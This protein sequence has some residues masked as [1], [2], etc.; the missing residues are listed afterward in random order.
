M[1]HRH[2]DEQHVALVVRRIAQAVDAVLDHRVLAELHALG[3]AGGAGAVHHDADVVGARRR[4]AGRSVSR[5]PARPRTHRRSPP[6]TM[7][8]ST[9]SRPIAHEAELLEQLVPDEHDLGGAVVEDV[10]ELVAGQ[11][12]VDDGRRG[13]ELAAAEDDL[14]HRRVVL[15]EDRDPVAASDAVGLERAGCRAYGLPGLGPRP[16]AFAE[17]PARLVGPLGRAMGEEVRQMVA[18]GMATGMM[19]L[20]CVTW[21]TTA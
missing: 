1:E 8:F 21:I 10:V 15:V 9:C 7:T 5:P 2:R 16:R 6:T 4:A 20:G 13:T 18:G 12:P 17:D 19:L 14:Q 3:S 11:A